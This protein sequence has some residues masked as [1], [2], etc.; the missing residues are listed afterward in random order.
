M[1]RFSKCRFYWTI[2][3]KLHNLL[4]ALNLFN[5]CISSPSVCIFFWICHLIKHYHRIS[6]HHT[7]F[8]YIFF[9]LPRYPISVGS[10]LCKSLGNFLFTDCLS[11]WQQKGSKII[12]PLAWKMDFGNGTDGVWSQLSFIGDNIYILR[13]KC[14]TNNYNMKLQRTYLLW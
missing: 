1:L 14:V 12:L 13:S 7:P 6:I 11:M 8:L 10:F 2:L 4:V 5:A 9:L 3:I